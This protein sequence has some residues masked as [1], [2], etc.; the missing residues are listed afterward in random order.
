M[1]LSF[2]EAMELGENYG[3]GPSSS[4]SSGSGFGGAFSKNFGKSFLDMWKN[5]NAGGGG[6]DDG[7]NYFGPSSLGGGSISPIGS[8]G[9]HFLYQYTHPQATIMP[10]APSQPGFGEQLAQTAIG[11]GVSAGV[12]SLFCDERLKVDIAP[13]E[14]TEVNDSLAEIAFF[15]KGLRECA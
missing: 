13:L 11:A 6:S 1:G 4:S 10:T 14:S 3:T 7:K 9:K 5:R 8:G 2:K 15:V 12:G